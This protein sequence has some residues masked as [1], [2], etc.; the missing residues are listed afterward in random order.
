VQWNTPISQLIRD[1]F[2]LEDGYKMPHFTIED[3]LSQR[4]GI[5]RYDFAMAL[6]KKS[7]PKNPVW[8]LPYLPKV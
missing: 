2:V 3:A 5:P 7:T 1:D 6:Q 4:T 8:S